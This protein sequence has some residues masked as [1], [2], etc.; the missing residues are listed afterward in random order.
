MYSDQKTAMNR[1]RSIGRQTFSNLAAMVK[2]NV[3]PNTSSMSRDC[4]CFSSKHSFS[5]AARFFAG[6]RI[7]GHDVESF[8]DLAQPEFDRHFLVF[9]AN[10]QLQHVARL[11]F[12][13]P[14][15]DSAWHFSTVPSQDDISS[16]QSRPGCLAFR[17]NPAHD[18]WA[19]R[20]V[21]HKEPKRRPAVFY[22]SQRQP[23]RR[24]NLLIREQ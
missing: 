15:I 1:V 4:A 3:K 14:M 7:F 8:L 2:L 6:V 19:V 5:N 17:I 10:S 22:S 13:N 18:E 9:P 20:L 23:R 11:L 16:A 21:L 24:Q 12:L